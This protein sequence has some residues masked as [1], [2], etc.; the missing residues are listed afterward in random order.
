MRHLRKLTPHELEDSMTI[1]ANAYPGLELTNRANRVRY[2]ERLNQASLDPTTN[3]YGLFE[4]GQMRGIM[5]WHD[6]TMN[7]F[8]EQTLV[9]G[10]G[11]LA[12]DLLHKKEKVAYEMVLA[13][14]RHYKDAGSPLTALYPFRP[15]FYRRMGFGYG[16]PMHRYRFLPASLPKGSTKSDMVFLGKNDG[17]KLQDCYQSYFRRTHGIMARRPQFWDIVLQEPSIQIVGICREDRLSGYVSFSFEKGRRTDFL[18]NHIYIR[19]LIYES[20]DDLGRLLTFL[21]TQADQVEQIV[22]NTQ[23][24]SFYYLLHDPRD[25]AEE[26]LPHDIAHVSSLQGLGIM[27]RVL[28][29]PRLFEVL[30]QHN[31]NDVTCC[32]QIDLSDS[33]FPENAGSYVIKVTSGESKLAP[34]AA[35]DVILAMDVADF[36]SLVTGVI[37]L[38][39]LVGYGL[40]TI[41]DAA[42]LG[43]LDRLFSGPKPVCLTSF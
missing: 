35:P 12:V 1:F 37:S 23:D 2:R 26:L 7:F 43:R 17:G 39:K 15:D 30:Q 3:F 21:Q 22:Y 27:Y 5:R 31:F 42:Y 13:F 20:L 10:L 32:L 36:S 4:D 19:E 8:G 29:V 14:L 28:D 18:S 6:F 40:A 34:D 9:G 16:T 24:D 33:F 11:G 38:R 25:S 41:S